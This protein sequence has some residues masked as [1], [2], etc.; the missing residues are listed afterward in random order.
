MPGFRRLCTGNVLTSLASA[1]LSIL[2]GWELYERT[3]ST[4]VLGM[5]GLVQIIPNLALAL[6]AGQYV[7]RN[8]PKHVAVAALTLEMLAAAAVGVL[9]LLTGPIWL[10]FCAIFLIG[11]GRAI[12][13]PTYAPILAGTVESEHFQ[14]ASAWNG[15]LDHT[16]AIVGPALGG[17]LVAITGRTGPIFL[18]CSALYAGAAVAI[19]SLVLRRKV[20]EAPDLSKDALLAGARFIRS[21]PIM[22]GSIL[23]DMFAVLLGGA[24]ALLPVFA[25]DVLHVGAAGLG[26][27]RAA[28]AAGA[29]L[30]ALAVAHHGP[31]QK[32]GRSL[33]LTV[34]GFGA[35]TI[36]FGLSRAFPL[37]VV[38]LFALG[39]FDSVSLIIRETI[40][41][42]FTPEAMRGRVASIHF[43]FI[44]LS[45]EFGEFESGVL[46]ALVGVTAAVTLGGMGTL[47]VVATISVL[48]PELRRLGRIEV[49]SDEAIEASAHSSS[50]A[51]A[52]TVG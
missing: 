9:T 23:L 16:A 3:D 41:M 12:K 26:V 22:F 5:V 50:V 36:V 49:D 21:T 35:A 44:G 14:D 32:A 28:P 52:D 18:G 29:L 45:N 34:A 15:G 2:V 6:P 48:I 27:M 7:D 39:A 10:I 33:L 40:E 42:R 1:I 24:T 47:G 31:I 38:A 11:V 19:G 37:S 46:A 4:L 25:E 51:T 43:M 8:N 30:A 17:L 13:N 20:T